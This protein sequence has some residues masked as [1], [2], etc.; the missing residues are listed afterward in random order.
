[1]PLIVDRI[2][3]LQF[4]RYVK[5]FEDNKHILRKPVRFGICGLSYKKNSDIVADSPGYLLMKYFE[6][7]F[8][9]F[10]YDEYISGNIKNQIFSLK[11]LFDKSNFLFVC[12]KDEKFRKLEKFKTNDQKV[13][14]DMWNFIKIKNKNIYLKKIGISH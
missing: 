13:I 10:F 3:N 7:K 1:L 12:Y 9:V 4:K 8:K 6:K 11:E 2:N 14:I 5:I